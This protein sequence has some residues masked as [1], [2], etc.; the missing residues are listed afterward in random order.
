M[1]VERYKLYFRCPLEFGKPANAIIFPRAMLDRRQVHADPTVD[2]MLREAAERVLQ[3]QARERELHERV[4]LLLRYSMDVQQ[5]SAERVARC[6]GLTLRTLR[7]RLAN[8]GFALS[9]LIDEARCRVACDALLR[10]ELSL[11]AVAEMVGFS[12]ASAFFRAFKRW[13]G[14]TPGEFRRAQLPGAS[15]SSELAGEAR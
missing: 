12:E 5:I 7:R 10:E 11:P 1:Y 13:T 9:T 8:E 3:G 2:R 4:R 6:F 14:R 15:E